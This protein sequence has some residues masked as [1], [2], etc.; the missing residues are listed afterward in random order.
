MKNKFFLVLT[1]TLLL[2][3]LLAC[4]GSTVPA[5]V[6]MENGDSDTLAPDVHTTEFPLPENFSQLTDTG[7]GTV[8]FQTN[9]GIEET[10][11]FYRQTFSDI[12]YMERTINT[13]I[14]ETTFSIVFDGHDSGQA[15][16]IQGVDLGDGNTNIS[17]RFEDI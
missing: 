4:N 16:I 10:I 17:I 8:N 2:L 14:T 13:A 1:L 11:S 6:T 5:I 7:S 12:G 15:I 3:P 9:L